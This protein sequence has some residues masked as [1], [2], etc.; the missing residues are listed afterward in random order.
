[1]W[2]D[3]QRRLERRLLTR[4]QERRRFISIEHHVGALGSGLNVH[5]GRYPM[6]KNGC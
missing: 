5:H 4:S 3:D 1:V 2:L 6:D